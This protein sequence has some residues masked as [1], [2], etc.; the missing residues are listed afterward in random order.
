MGIAR[1]QL[2][3]G[4]TGQFIKITKGEHY[5]VDSIIIPAGGTFEHKIISGAVL[6]S[7]DNGGGLEA[8]QYTGPFVFTNTSADTE[9]TC[10]VAGLILFGVENVK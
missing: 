8:K 9:L 2:Y 1:P 4:A 5:K 3:S 6:L 7:I 10:D